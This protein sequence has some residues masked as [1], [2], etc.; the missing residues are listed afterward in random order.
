MLTL[1]LAHYFIEGKVVHL[2]HHKKHAVRVSN[3]VPALNDRSRG[4]EMN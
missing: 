1:L 3:F 2:K 4:L